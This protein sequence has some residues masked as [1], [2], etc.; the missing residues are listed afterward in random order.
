M[1]SSGFLIFFF[2]DEDSFSSLLPISNDALICV[3]FAKPIPS[4][5]HNSSIET[6]SISLKVLYL[7]RILLASSSALSPSF[8]VLKIIL[9]SFERERFFSPYLINISLGLSSLTQ[10]L[11]ETYS[12]FF[13]TSFLI[14]SLNLS[15]LSLSFISNKFL[16]SSIFSSFKNFIFFLK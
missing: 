11:I 10:F 13:K 16:I 7:L 2:S 5:L 14:S 1:I 8:P 12:L 9:R 15:Q 4:I 6:E 3:A